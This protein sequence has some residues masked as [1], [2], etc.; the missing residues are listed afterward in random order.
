M[1]KD[2]EYLRPF[3]C[4]GGF[5]LLAV[6]LIN[7]FGNLEIPLQLIFYNINQEIIKYTAN[8]G[9]ML[10]FA[11]T[12]YL[13]YLIFIKRFGL[14]LI[15]LG[16]I[17]KNRI[18]MC[19]IEVIAAV[20]VVR[21]IWHLQILFLGYIGYDVETSASNEPLFMLIYAIIGAPIMEEMVF[22]GW[23][24]NILKKYGVIPA[25]L[26]SSLAFGLF[27]GTV[28]QSFPAFLIG[29]ILS[30]LALKYKS[31]IP[32]M[33]IHMVTNTM[34]TLAIP[35]FEEKLMP[36]FMIASGVILLVWL[37]LNAR[38]LFSRIK[39]LPLVFRL[40]VKSLSWAVFCLISLAMIIA[41]YFLG[42]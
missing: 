12:Y 21:V 35:S 14:K 16:K 11:Y 3:R 36:Y 27:H 4:F 28:L 15:D 20:V 38:K 10:G 37:I 17:K 29:L 2:R 39:E 23:L 41:G 30:Y 32:G 7:I 25:I 24:L 1:M 40:S 6:I 5:M 8:L 42:F 33:A 9:S 13:G 22:R 18:L 34:S 26:F 31:L 19:I